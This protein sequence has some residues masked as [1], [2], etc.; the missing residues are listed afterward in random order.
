MPPNFGQICGKLLLT[1][2]I[3][4]SV[5]P[6]IFFLLPMFGPALHP[7]VLLGFAPPNMETNTSLHGAT[8]IG[9]PWASQVDRTLLCELPGTSA[10]EPMVGWRSGKCSTVERLMKTPASRYD[11]SAK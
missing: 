9:R 4:L 2:A 1:T 10:E 11:M 6:L 7:V 5:P 3:G 8:V